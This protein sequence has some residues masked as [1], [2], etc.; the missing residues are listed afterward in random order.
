M[1]VGSFK[2]PI[3]IGG[4]GVDISDAHAAVG[5]VLS[6]KTFY[7]TS[8]GKKT[9]TML[10]NGTVST[11]ISAVATEVTIAAGKHS[12]S[13]KVKISTT[14][15]AKIIAGNIKKDVVILGVTGTVE[16]GGATSGDYLV[17]FLDIDGTILKTQWVNSGQDATAPTSPTRTYLTFYGW[18]TTYTGVTRSLDVGVIYVTTDGKSYLFIR[19]SATTGLSPTLYVNKSTT[20]TMTINWGDTTTSTNS[21]SGNQ[22]IAHTYSV[23]G[24]YLITVTCSTTYQFGQ[25]SSP[26]QIF[27]GNYANI[28]KSVY[29]GTNVTTLPV[30]AFNNCYS[31]TS[32]SIPSTVTSIGTYAFNN[33]YALAYISIPSTVT[34][35]GTNAFYYCYSLSS[36]IIPS[37]VTSISAYIFYNCYA[38]TYISIP[39]GVT[40][41]GTNAFDSCYSLSSIIIPSGTNSIGAYAFYYCYSLSSIIIPSGVTSISAS[42]F[43]NCKKLKDYQILAT[44]PPTLTA[45]AFTGLSMITKIYVPDASVATYKAATNW[46]TY[47][48]YIY[49]ISTRP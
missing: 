49:P 44:I 6:A 3:A 48:A 29:I 46:T 1:A 21:S 37:S 12:G 15:Q 26:T 30:Y 7:A 2:L 17:R 45:G 36:I 5:D 11:D 41:I 34:S 47:A 43:Y 16:S 19:I 13:G 40:S 35:I 10:D 42:I 23:E 38:L 27:T 33:C 18:N 20:A 25:G 9:G 31:L 28:V 24:D 8:G 4:G 32:I 39:S 22:T 14:E